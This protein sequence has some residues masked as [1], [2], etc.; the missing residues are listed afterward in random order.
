[1]SLKTR[2]RLLEKRTVHGRSRVRALILG[3]RDSPPLMLLDGEWLPCKALEA[4]CPAPFT[5]SEIS[6]LLSLGR[7]VQSDGYRSA[8]ALFTPI[9]FGEQVVG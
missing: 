6:Y 4:L 5:R 8:N 3:L 2:I 7:V 1:M 9:S